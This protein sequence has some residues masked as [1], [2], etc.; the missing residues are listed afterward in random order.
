[1]KWWPFKKKKKVEYLDPQKVNFTQVDITETFDDHLTLSHDDWIDTLPLN[2]FTSGPPGNLPPS[3]ASDDEVYR[4]ASELSQIRETFDLPDVACTVRSVTSPTLIV[5][6]YALRV[7]NATDRC[8]LLVGAD[9]ERELAVGCWLLA[10][11]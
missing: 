9:T 4:I 6:A 3:D 1:M 11:S 2:S 10:N 8:W 7:R 5:M